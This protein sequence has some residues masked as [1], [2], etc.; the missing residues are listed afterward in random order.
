MSKAQHS[1]KL[2]GVIKSEKVWIPA[3]TH[4]SKE[5]KLFQ[6][7]DEKVGTITVDLRD[8]FFPKLI[9]KKA[10]YALVKHP[11]LNYLV[12]TPEVPGV[13]IHVMLKKITGNLS[14]WA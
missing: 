4:Q 9:T 5:V 11:E 10:T 14:Y 13:K 12:P 6:G 1:V 7:I 2:T 3:K 8:A